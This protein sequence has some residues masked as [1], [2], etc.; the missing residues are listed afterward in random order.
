MRQSASQVMSTSCGPTLM[1]TKA[2][3]PLWQLYG[4]CVRMCVSVYVYVWVGVGI[5]MYGCICIYR[6]MYGCMYVYVYVCRTRAYTLTHSLTHTHTHS[7]T[8]THPVRGRAH[9][10][11]AFEDETATPAQRPVPAYSNTIGR[12]YQTHSHPHPH[13][14]PYSQPHPSLHPLR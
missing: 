14:H 10:F 4:V 13:P 5:F 9:T 12:K 3:R 7:L 6:C 2:T 1:N 11:T 8:H